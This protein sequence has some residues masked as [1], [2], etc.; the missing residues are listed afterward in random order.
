MMENKTRRW[1]LVLGMH[2]SGTSAIAGALAHNGIAFGDSFIELQGDV[3]EKGFWEHA[4]LVAINEALLKELGAAW[5]DPFSLMTQF[6]QGW[7]PS[8]ALFGRMCAFLRHPEFADAQQCG[9]KDPRLSVLLP[10]WQQAMSYMGDEACYLLMN[11]DM[12]QVARSLQKRDQ[13]SLL[14]GQLLWGEYTFSAEAYTRNLPRCWLDYEAMLANPGAALAHIQLQLSLSTTASADFID[15]SMQRQLSR[16]S[17]NSRVTSLNVLADKIA[18]YGEQILEHDWS[19]WHAHYRD[20]LASAELWLQTLVTDFR[21][22]NTALV[23]SLHL[24]ESHSL[25]LATID[26]RDEQLALLQQ[27]LGVLGEQHAIA[28]DTL[29]VRDAEI[30]RLNEQLQEEGEAHGYAIRIVE[31]RDVALNQ[32]NLEIDA[33]KQRI[34]DISQVLEEQQLHLNAIRAHP[35]LH[36][37]I[38]RFVTKL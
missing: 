6:E 16:G 3:N 34:E 8:D 21:T 5:F 25:A 18:A 20:E 14:L 26:Q 24:G 12:D 7:R 29:R 23:A 17:K 35:M 10:C 13:M 36:W 19:H 38:N 30:H 33:Y 32:C 15:P 37:F 22:L 2:R 31:Q 27:Q 28:L 1:I 11:R 9:L 4:E